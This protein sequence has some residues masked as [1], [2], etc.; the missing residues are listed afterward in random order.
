MYRLHEIKDVT[1]NSQ[2]RLESVT[3]RKLFT[4]EDIA[5]A[6]LAGKELV[7]EV[8]ELQSLHLDLL[9]QELRPRS[10]HGHQ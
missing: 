3:I 7:D 6:H 4:K 1:I 5:A 10:I 8:T 2:N 9:E